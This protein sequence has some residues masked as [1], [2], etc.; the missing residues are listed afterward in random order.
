MLRF[1][2]VF[3]L[4]ALSVAPVQAQEGDA[5][6]GPEPPPIQLLRYDEDYSYLEHASRR[7]SL[8]DPIK[9]IRLGNAFLG[10]GTSYLSL[11]G[12]A[13]LRPE[14]FHRP[15]LGAGPVAADLFLLQ[16]YMLHADLHLGSRARIFGQLQSGLTAGA[17]LG[18]RP[19]DRNALDLHQLF[20]DGVLIERPETRFTVRAGRQELSYGMGRL[21]GVREGPN[22]RQTFE[23][24]KAVVEHDSYRAD[25]L[26]AHPVEI[27]PGTFD[28]G[29]VR[30][31]ET[32]WGF[33]T[34]TSRRSFPRGVE[35][36]YLGF[37]EEEAVFAQ[38]RGRDLRHTIGTRLF[39][40][41]GRPYRY[42]LEAA[43]QAGRFREGAARAWWLFADAGYTYRTAFLQPAVGLLASAASGDRDPADA[44]LQ[45]FNPPFPRNSYFTLIDIV[46]G[47][48]NLY[49]LKPSA[50]AELWPR[51]PVRLT[52][53]WEGYWRQRTTDAVYGP[54]KFPLRPQPDGPRSDA[55]FT[56]HQPSLTL[57]AQAGRHLQFRATY[58]RFVPGPVIRETGPAD[59]VDWATLETTFRF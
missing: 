38:G 58:V 37:R 6:A 48:K 31:V 16:R 44:D 3:V 27:D 2:L 17:E 20:V 13:R 47:F 12:E 34:G 53:A 33:Y 5:E 36:Y 1:L 11:G 26:L 8:F 51:G 24:L 50:G 14:Y 32:L 45:T 39:S 4:I 28:D 40:P 54:S 46:G 30:P 7:T 52:A 29:P 43:F 23:S 56:G 35:L 15:R 18:P 25:L 49:H 59:P 9:Y 41:R 19:I 42:D 22:V 10:G 21:I 55:R 57:T